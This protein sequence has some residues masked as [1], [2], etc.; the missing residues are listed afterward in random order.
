MEEP[1][2][3]GKDALE[4]DRKEGQGNQTCQYKYLL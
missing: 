2:T 3:A 1:T 4:S